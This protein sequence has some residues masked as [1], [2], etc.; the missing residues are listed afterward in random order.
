MQITGRNLCIV[1]EAL[2]D[3]VSGLRN[4]IATCPDVILYSEDLDEYEAWIMKY[5][6]LIARVDRALI[7]EGYAL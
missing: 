1:R 6:K 3:A 7:K 5:E 4:Q 2:D